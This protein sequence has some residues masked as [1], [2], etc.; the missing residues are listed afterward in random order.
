MGCCPEVVLYVGAEAAKGLCART[1]VLGCRQTPKKA[2]IPK[3]VVAL[4]QY[5]EYHNG[6]DYDD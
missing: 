5:G 2:K 3:K 4:V 1:G 6:L